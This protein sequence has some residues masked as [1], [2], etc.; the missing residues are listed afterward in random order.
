MAET[1]VECVG[2]HVSPIKRGVYGEISK[3]EEEVAEVVDAAGQGN[4]LMTLVELSDVIGAIDGYL[5][6]HFGGEI[7]LDDLIKLA[8]ATQR[9]FNTGG[10]KC[11]EDQ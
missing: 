4:R 3:I 6:K 2:Y 11:R 1:T 10:R 8:R 5:S 7:I 9:A